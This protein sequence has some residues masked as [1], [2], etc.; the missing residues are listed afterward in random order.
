MA[1]TFDFST[2]TD[3]ISRLHAIYMWL[4]TN[5][6]PITTVDDTDIIGDGWASKFI[7]EEQKGRAKFKSVLEIDNDENAIW[8][9]LIWLS[10]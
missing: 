6:G 10:S 1:V 8:F 9:K 5:V 7:V 2:E 4:S 3:N